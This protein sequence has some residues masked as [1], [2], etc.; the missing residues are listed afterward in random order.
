MKL[1]ILDQSPVVP[2]GSAA[3]AIAQTLRLAQA[4]ENLG[5]T[6]Y[7]VSEHHNTPG[8]AGSTPEVLISYLASHTKTMRVGS[9]GVLLPHYSPL[10]VAENFRMLETL[11]PG[12]IDLGIGRAPGGDF[13]T[14]L[15][16]NEGRRT[17][18]R[19]F[20][21][22]VKTL[23]GFLYNSLPEE[24]PYAAVR[25]NPVGDSAPEVWLLGSSDASALYAAELG[26]AFSFAQFIN[27]DGGPDMVRIYKQRFQPS[28][29]LAAPN[30]MASV[31]VLCAGTEEEAEDLAS[32]MDLRLLWLEQG[33]AGVVPSREEAAGYPFTPYE[34]FRVRENR[35]RMVVGDPDSVR[36]Q[37]LRLA[38]Q[39]GV[40]ELMVVT[41]TDRFESRLRSY[42]LLAEACL[43]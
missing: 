39:Y 17:N 43:T 20:P 3:E 1:S 30:A 8:L 9:G 38:E 34:R 6:R 14:T 31:F 15:A 12:R 29:H 41:I 4:A 35:K 26:T 32:L 16:L 40:D 5:Y 37:L 21:E 19:E 23:K 42:E 36:K 18:L 27:G 33:R 11:F 10:K 25:A 2:S 7:W 28:A 24:H 22:K 13:L